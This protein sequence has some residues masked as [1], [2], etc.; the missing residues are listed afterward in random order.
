MSAFQPKRQALN[1]RCAEISV[2]RQKCGE[3]MVTTNAAW[4]WVPPLDP[5]I[6]QP[7]LSQN[8]SMAQRVKHLTRM[9]MTPTTCIDRSETIPGPKSQGIRGTS[10]G[11]ATTAAAWE[12]MIRG[13]GLAT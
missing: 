5:H 11:A 1:I 13:M 6:T 12:E 10:K 9:N 2:L 4:S 7:S 3:L 8:N